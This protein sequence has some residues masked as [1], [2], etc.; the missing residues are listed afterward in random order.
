MKLNDLLSPYKYFFRAEKKDNQDILDFFNAITMDTSEFSVRYD[1]GTDFFAFTKE[2]SSDVVVFIMRDEKGLVKGT[3]S[4]CFLPHTYN[5]KKE[6]FAYLGDLR[7]S[8]TLSAKIR[9]NW[10]KCYSEI[11]EHFTSIEEFNG[12]KYLY[13]A[14]LDDNQNAMRSLLKNN[15]Q[16]IYHRLTAYETFN[17]LKKDFIQDKNIITKS[18]S[19]E[20]EWLSSNDQKLL[21]FYRDHVS[22]EGLAPYYSRENLE[23]CELN[24]HLKNWKGLDQSKALVVIERSSKKI[25]AATI[26][27]MCDSKK[28][29]IE[30]MS[31]KQKLLSL[32]SPLVG[33][34][35]LK[36]S[37]S[38]K[39]LYLTHL[40]FALNA[41]ADSRTVILTK[42]LNTL[43]ESTKNKTRDFHV[44]SFFVFNEWSIQKLPF[45]I[46]KTKAQFYQVMCKKQFDESDFID[47]KNNAPA[48][49]IG[50]A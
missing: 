48:F 16:L 49:E 39:V 24:Y 28:L 10:K 37:Q 23:Q 35:S 15:D 33:I 1:R 47:L 5:G 25:L 12:V 40:H 11:I 36:E 38:I 8:P 44:I 46:E 29:V 21:S 7:I 43:F 26:P 27:W 20:I 45:M 41:P 6:I 2:Q 34:P 50:S 31:T 14:I 9:I 42:I 17:V 13:S 30:R 3:A 22:S 18:K 19:Y 4:I 32:I